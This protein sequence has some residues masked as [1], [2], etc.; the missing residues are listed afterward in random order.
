MTIF[1]AFLQSFDAESLDKMLNSALVQIQAKMR[2]GKLLRCDF[3]ALLPL[4]FI[5][6]GFV[7]RVSKKL[8]IK[9]SLFCDFSD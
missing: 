6:T 2:M 3:F 7:K 1:N 8:S 9:S 5:L 4:K